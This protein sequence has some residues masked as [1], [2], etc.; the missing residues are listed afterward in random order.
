MSTS[1]SSSGSSGEKMDTLE[2]EMYMNSDRHIAKYYNAVLAKDLLPETA[3]KPGFYIV[4]Q[5]SSNKE[6]SH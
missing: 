1:G 5:D 6:L 4:N 3:I 2:L